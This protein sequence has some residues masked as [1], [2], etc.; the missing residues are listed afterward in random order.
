MVQVLLTAPLGDARDADL[1]FLLK[2]HAVSVC[3]LFSYPH[4]P[5]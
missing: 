2:V 5:F 3:L 4:M 1:D